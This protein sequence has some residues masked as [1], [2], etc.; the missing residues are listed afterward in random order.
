MAAQSC[1]RPVSMRMG[2]APLSRNTLLIGSG[3]GMRMLTTFACLGTA[4]GIATR[5]RKSAG[6][7]Y[8]LLADID[9]ARDFPLFR[10]AG[11]G[12][13]HDLGDRITLRQGDLERTEIGDLQ[14][15]VPPPARMD[16][17]SCHVDKQPGARD[18]T[19]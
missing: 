5:T 9:A 3:M 18:G 17:G 12:G 2:R 14:R 4:S 7:G 1:G 6:A 8:A 13:N 15:N 16:R 19:A 11:N 10:R